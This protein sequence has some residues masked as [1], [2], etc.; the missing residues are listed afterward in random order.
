[1][2]GHVWKV[3]FIRWLLF[4]VTQMEGFGLG[5]SQYRLVAF[6]GQNGGFAPPGDNAHGHRRL[7]PQDISTKGKLQ[8]RR[9]GGWSAGVVTGWRRVC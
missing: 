1:M 4:F 7:P 9:V 6:S 5:K 2:I 8:S 3:I